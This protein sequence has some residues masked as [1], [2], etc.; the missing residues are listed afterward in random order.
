MGGKVVLCKGCGA[1]QYIYFSC[2]NA[3]CPICQGLKRLTW[4]KQLSDKLLELPY[5]HT[6]FTLPFQLRSLA[7]KYPKIIYNLLMRT[8]W[9]T[10]KTLCLKEENVGG[11]PGMIAVL[12]TFGSDMKFHPHVHCLITFGG[13][14]KQQN[15]WCWPTRK[16]KVASFR[17]MCSTYRSLFLKQLD[18]LIEK[19]KISPGNLWEQTRKELQQVRWNVNNT[20]PTTET[21][22][23]ENYL[24]RYIN[25]IAISK[26]RLCYVREQ[27]QVQILYKDYKNQKKNQPAPKAVKYLHPL[28]AIDQIMAHVLPVYFQKSRYY[29][30]HAPKTYKKIKDHIPEHLKRNNQTIRILFI[31][32]NHILNLTPWECEYCNSKQFDI[33]HLR[34]Q[35]DIIHLPPNH[36]WIKQFLIGSFY[37]PPPIKPPLCFIP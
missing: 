36:Q 6:V 9:Q 5:V 10:I 29:G 34:K 15:K 13:W 27:N 19:G 31:I 7:K 37:R 20:Y 18:R 35:F 17:K 1:K 30:I 16:N 33:I 14:N 32:L 2:G 21:A 3:Q 23:I 24:S 11:L 25:R 12:H 4:Q 28:T 8:A 26:S 22:I